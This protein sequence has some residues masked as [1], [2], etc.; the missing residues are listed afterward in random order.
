M[1][2]GEVVMLPATKSTRST[3]AIDTEKLEALGWRQTKTLEGYI[4]EAKKGV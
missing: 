1:F 2:G 3:G 4:A